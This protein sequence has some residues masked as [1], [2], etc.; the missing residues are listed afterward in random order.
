MF[1]CK[2]TRTKDLR[3]TILPL[4]HLKETHFYQ[5]K[6]HSNPWKNPTKNEKTT[7]LPSGNLT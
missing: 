7:P 6:G 3:K 4:T 2:E 5:K 1:L